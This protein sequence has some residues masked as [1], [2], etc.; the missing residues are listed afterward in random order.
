VQPESCIRHGRQHTGPLYDLMQGCPFRLATNTHVYSRS[1]VRFG[2][3]P[4]RLQPTDGSNG[5]AP[6]PTDCAFPSQAGKQHRYRCILDSE[7]SSI[8]E[9]I[10]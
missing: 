10:H 3:L 8:T 4:D 6:S 2:A 9:I 7:A 5:R 1:C